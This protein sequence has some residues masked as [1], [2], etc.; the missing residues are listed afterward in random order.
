MSVE[1]LDDILRPARGSRGGAVP[2]RGSARPR[3][4]SPYELPAVVVCMAVNLTLVVFALVLVTAGWEWLESKPLVGERK[5]ELWTVVGFALFALPYAFVGRHAHLV[6]ARGN[7]V[8]VSASQMPELHEILEREC[9]ALG[10]TEIPELFV[11]HE[12]DAMASAYSVVGRRSCV[13]IHAELLFTGA[14]RSHLDVIAFA[15]GHGLGALR[16]GHT[17][18]WLEALTAYA[19]RIPGLRTPVLEAF[20]FSRDRCAAFVAPGGVRGLLIQAA[21][22][23]LIDD[24]DL[25]AFLE[26]ARSFGGLWA[27]ISGLARRTTPHVCA[28]VRTLYDAGFFDLE[29]DL[30]RFAPADA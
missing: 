11:S 26:Q 21:G 12:L 8:R 14:W 3:L 6:N 20:T 9:E 7:G 25:R 28:R 10:L 16:L 29:R 23:E 1:V 24:V 18:W 2:T 15:I 17:R 13:V 5:A 4:R 19:I 30:S 22:K 27:R